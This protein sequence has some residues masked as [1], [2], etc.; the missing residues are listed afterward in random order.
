[1]SNRKPKTLKGAEGL[2]GGRMVGG[3]LSELANYSDLFIRTQDPIFL[4]DPETL[5]VLECNPAAQQALGRASGDIEGDQW[6]NWVKTSQQ[7]QIKNKLLES[8]RSQRA[9]APF[10]CEM[11]NGVVFEV[12]ACGLKLADYGE[13][14]QVI[15]KDVTEVRAARRELEEMNRR[16]A[17]ASI[18]DEMTGLFN[19]RHFMHEL[20]REHERSVR[21]KKT[22]S[23]IFCDV[24]HFKKYNDQNG[25]PAGDAALKKVAEILKARARKTDL[26]ARYGGEEFV[27]LCPD[28]DL[29]QAHHLA[30]SLRHAVAESAFPHGERQPLGKVSL[31]LGVAAYPGAGM[32]WKEVLGAADQAVY[33]SKHLGRNRV[34]LST[35]KSPLASKKAS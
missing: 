24:D 9:I 32:S 14:I 30:E 10:D 29:E 1:V 28:T 13:L 16:L 25:H 35:S 18:T 23:I 22:Y 34:S 2:L 31:S 8:F 5:K 20:E 3:R 17:E 33:E 11:G 27:V 4:L 6:I 12:S 19:Y 15:A 26:Y 7:D 21:F